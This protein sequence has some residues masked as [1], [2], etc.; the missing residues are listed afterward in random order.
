MKES[1]LIGLLQSI[2]PEELRWLVKLGA[3]ALLQLNESC[4]AV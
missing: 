1:K 2:P 4:G 3:V